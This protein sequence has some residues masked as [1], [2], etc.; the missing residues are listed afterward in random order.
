MRPFIPW[1]HYLMQQKILPSG[2]DYNVMGISLKEDGESPTEVKLD[3]KF[4]VN[5]HDEEQFEKFLADFSKSSGT[6]YNK[7][8]HADRQEDCIIWIQKMYS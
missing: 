2:Y 3:A 7:K 6:A 4:R 5:A 8:N 1:R